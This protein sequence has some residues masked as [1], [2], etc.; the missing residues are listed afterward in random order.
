MCNC[1]SVSESAVNGKSWCKKSLVSAVKR[2]VNNINSSLLDWFQNSGLRQIE[3]IQCQFVRYCLFCM[4]RKCSSKTMQW[5]SK[6][7]LK[8][9]R[10]YYV[11]IL[12]VFCENVFIPVSVNTLSFVFN[13][14]LMSHLHT[15][16]IMCWL[17]H[18]SLDQ[19]F[20]KTWQSRLQWY[21]T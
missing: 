10:C 6:L 20:F 2:N 11:W 12:L 18:F 13:D 5:Y 7:Y 14:L 4:N 15:I 19:Y 9:I 21:W 1:A 17:Q 3:H 8:L 16:W